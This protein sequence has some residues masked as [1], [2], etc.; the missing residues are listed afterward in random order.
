MSTRLI[1]LRFAALGDSTG[2][3]VG[4]TTGG[5]YV[6]RL[7]KKLREHFTLDARNFCQ[8]GATVSRLQQ[9]QLRPALI[10]RPE[11]ATVA[12]GGNDVWRGTEL[13]EYEASLKTV[14]NKLRAV[15][16][17]TIVVN[18]P[19]LSI[20]PVAQL[21]PREWYDGRIEAF[22]EIIDRVARDCSATRVDLYSKSR[23]FAANGNHT[24]LFC[25]DGF[26]PSSRGYEAWTEAM[27]PTVLD[28]ARR[29][30]VA[31]A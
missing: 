2:V 13:R 1:P 8:S 17:T 29:V 4:A 6:S 12:I 26:H 25:A 9:G 11:L 5:G 27:W 7:E 19:D 3:G 23:H 24:D 30:A 28:V 16:A 20:A 18:V 14:L 31:A 10:F 15:G 22:N 21:V